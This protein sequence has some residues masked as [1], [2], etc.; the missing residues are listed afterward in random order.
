MAELD[1]VRLN[2][3]TQNLLLLNVNLGVITFGVALNL[4][5]DDFKRIAHH[6]RPAL[7]GVCSPFLLLPAVTFLLVCFLQ[8]RSS[9]A[10]GM[11][12]IAACPGGNISNFISLNADGNTALYATLTA[13]ATVGAHCPHSAESLR[14]S[15]VETYP[16]DRPLGPSPSSSA[17]L[18]SWR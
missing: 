17:R 3:S 12:L 16:S 2:F 14:F 9:I 10:L 1:A 5:V 4:T 7:I 11:I 6:P 13:V 8:Q 15:P 18:S